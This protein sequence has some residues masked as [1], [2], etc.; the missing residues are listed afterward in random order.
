MQFKGLATIITV[1][2]VLT[3]L[4]LAVVLA[5]VQELWTYW[6]IVIPG[7]IGI[8]SAIFW[9]WQ[10]KPYG[11]DL[12]RV[13]NDF[14]VWG[15]ALGFVVG[16]GMVALF[17]VISLGVMQQSA[18]HPC[19]C[20]TSQRGADWANLALAAGIMSFGFVV[21]FYGMI[22]CGWALVHRLR[23]RERQRTTPS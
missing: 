7:T 23:V 20:L 8:E 12:R 3:A 5:V 13:I 19:L 18:T 1:G 4:I 10:S 2:C 22:I 15:V 9:K 16:P 17:I 11:G 14:P 21:A 6:I